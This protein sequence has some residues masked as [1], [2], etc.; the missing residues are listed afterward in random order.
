M[1]DDNGI[2]RLRTVGEVINTHLYHIVFYQA[3]NDNLRI[4]YA[5]ILQQLK[6]IQLRDHDALIFLKSRDYDLIRISFDK[7]TTKLNM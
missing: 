4:V 1:I 7:Q 6:A 5:Q 2:S 3:V